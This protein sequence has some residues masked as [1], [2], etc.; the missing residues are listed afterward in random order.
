M[1]YG[2]TFFPTDPFVALAMAA[3]ATEGPPDPEVS[4][5]AAAAGI[6]RVLFPLPSL[7]RDGAP[8]ALDALAKVMG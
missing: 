2:L 3:E 4:K 8:Q 6:A 7:P 5:R 1:K